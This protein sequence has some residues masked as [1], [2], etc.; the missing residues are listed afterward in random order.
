[1]ICASLRSRRRSAGW[2]RGDDTCIQR[3][4][5]A[6]YDVAQ[7]SGRFPRACVK[8]LRQAAGVSRQRRVRAEAE[9]AVLDRMTEAYKSRIRQRASGASLP[10]ECLRRKAMRAAAPTGGAISQCRASTEEVVFTRNATEAINLV[11]SSWGEPNI[12]RAATKSCISIMEH[13]SNIVPWHFLQRAA[14]RG[15]Q[16]GAGRRRWQLPDRRVR[17]SC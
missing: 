4:P 7:R 3:S 8:S 14:W 5:M 16:V 13:H 10:R 6:S 17:E 9:A 1:M 2:R 11:A 12:K 15:H